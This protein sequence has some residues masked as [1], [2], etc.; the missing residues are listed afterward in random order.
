[1]FTNFHSSAFNPELPEKIM[2]F[3]GVRFKMKNPAKKIKKVYAAIMFNALPK[4]NWRD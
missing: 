2:L 1:L 4:E 3:S